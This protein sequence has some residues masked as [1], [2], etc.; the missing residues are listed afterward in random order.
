[1]KT[2]KEFSEIFKSFCTCSE[3]HQPYT[4]E[5]SAHY[6]TDLTSHLNRY[7]SNEDRV[8]ITEKAAQELSFNLKSQLPGDAWKDVIRSF[9]AGN[10]WNFS[11]V[12]KKPEIKKTEEQK[13]FWKFF[14]YAWMLFLAMIIFKFAILYM[15]M[16]SAEN[17]N[18][19]SP[20]W[21]VLICALSVGSLAYFAYRNRNDNG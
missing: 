14:N 7:F 17:P 9:I 3:I 18:Q 12:E 2:E 20:F 1:M 16:Q 15:G 4:T 11:T 6:W 10:H 19:V 5:V 13:I 21:V 8:L